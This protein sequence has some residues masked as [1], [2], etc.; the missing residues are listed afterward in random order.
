[1]P[2][3]ITRL[4]L[5][6]V[7][8]SL[9]TSGCSYIRQSETDQQPNPNASDIVIAT[10]GTSALVRRF[11][12]DIARALVLRTEELATTLIFS[13]QDL[14]Q[15]L[16]DLDYTLQQF[17]KLDT[18]LLN[19]KYK[20]LLHR[21]RMRSISLHQQLNNWEQ[22]NHMTALLRMIPPQSFVFHSSDKIQ[23]IKFQTLKIPEVL[24]SLKSDIN[25]NNNRGKNYAISNVHYCEILGRKDNNL[26]LDRYQQ[27]LSY[28]DLD[29]Q[30]QKND[31]RNFKT[32][33]NE[34]VIPAI[35]NFCSFLRIGSNDTSYKEEAN[36]ISKIPLLLSENSRLSL[37]NAI[38]QIDKKLIELNPQ[39]SL[40]E[41]YDRHVKASLNQD[42]I[43]LDQITQIVAD[44]HY[45]LER[46]F[47]KPLNREVLIAASD[48]IE[49][50]PFYF[51]SNTA[52]FDLTLV[53]ALPVFELETLAYLYT[54][55]GVHMLAYNTTEQED[56]LWRAY[57]SA[58]SIYALS[59]PEQPDYYTHSFSRIAVQSRKKFAMIMALTDI[60]L[61]E[62]KWSIDQAKNYLYENSPYPMALIAREITHLVSSP[63][64][65]M[66]AWM[67]SEA[68][69]KLWRLDHGLTRA[70]FN[71]RLLTY[72]PANLEFLENEMPI[73]I[74][75]K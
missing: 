20:P 57:A 31:Y 56:Q 48:Q 69:E 32:T 11:E 73:I 4:F 54:I 37:T 51:K 68:L 61:S 74:L 40:R 75:S 44:L 53:S 34:Q 52:F 71:D 3:Q 41:L 24:T 27:I 35:I 42:Q 12:N 33:V 66:K 50:S 49:P 2:R 9:L 19:S 28:S 10:A 13:K 23:D 7:L 47:I 29:V 18:T 67:I 64:E 8:F 14:T 6:T 1:M 63:N 55:P 72:S 36:T 60:N 58:W 65:A 70:E 21:L 46:W 59:L 16:K 26:I 62:N 39:S 43:S 38:T 15:Q 25:R 22:R 45:G 17:S 30:A 5:S